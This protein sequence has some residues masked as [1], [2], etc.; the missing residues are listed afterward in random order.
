MAMV[1]NLGHDPLRVA[2]LPHA[3]QFQR[4][5]GGV[6]TGA[7]SQLAHLIREHRLLRAIDAGACGIPREATSCQFAMKSAKGSQVKGLVLSQYDIYRSAFSERKRAS[8]TGL[9]K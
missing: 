7:F 9:V 8:P 2:Y 5:H 6:L 4:F 3:D 1:F